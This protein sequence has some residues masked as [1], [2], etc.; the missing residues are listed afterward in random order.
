MPITRN[1]PDASKFNNAA[2]LPYELRLEDFRLA[3]QDAYD[4]F[5]DVNAF[6]HGKGLPRLDEMLRPAAMSGVLS[7]LL[8]D[9]VA[10]HS[11]TLAVNRRH[12]GHPDLVVRG[13]Y[14]NDATD[15]GEHG[16]EVKST[17]NKGGAVDVH[18][19][20]NQWMCVFVYV[21]DNDS[22]PA[23]E[24][25]PMTF[26][27]AYIAQ[28]VVSDFRLNARRGDIGTRTATLHRQGLKKLRTNWVYLAQPASPRRTASR[29]SADRAISK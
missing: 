14:A 28:V 4:F 10:R 27:E 24:R 25:R 7:D 19:A 9:S 11:R 17:R 26:T 6:L 5:Y 29:G 23:S 15:T 13:R 20:R 16:I 2:S 3:M 1:Q 22:E 8:T 21:V 18:G 12:N